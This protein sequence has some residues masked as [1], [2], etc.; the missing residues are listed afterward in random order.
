MFQRS[1]VIGYS[2]DHWTE[3]SDPIPKL[4]GFKS[5][6]YSNINDVLYL[7]VFLNDINSMDINERWTRF[8]IY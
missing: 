6:L 1:F 4:H 8:D 7:R 5:V 2:C 3:M